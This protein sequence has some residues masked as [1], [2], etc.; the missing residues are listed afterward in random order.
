MPY[1]NLN[2][3]T[4]QTPIRN[5]NTD[6]RKLR[7]KAYNNTKWRKLRETFIREHAICEDCLSKGKI[8]PSQDVHHIKTP[9]Q[10][11]NINYNL[12]LD[13]TNLVALC[14]DCHG[15][16][17]AKEQGHTTIE[18]LIRQLDELMGEL[19]DATTA[20]SQFNNAMEDIGFEDEDD[21][22]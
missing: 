18:E 2:K 22:N 9:F 1:I 4:Q 7:Q 13:Y 11:G 16:R 3:K 20:V 21:D 10:N 15:A 14:K 17:H 12:L 8:T 6:A 5:E 19:D